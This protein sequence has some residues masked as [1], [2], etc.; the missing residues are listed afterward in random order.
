MVDHTKD[1]QRNVRTLTIPSNDSFLMGNQ[2]RLL[3]VLGIWLVTVA[4]A[5]ERVVAQPGEAGG[6]IEFNRD[7]RPIF[8]QYC[9]ACHGGVKAAA[10]LNVTQRDSVMARLEA[11]DAASSE[12]FRRLF[13]EDDSR[14]P[15][16]DHDSQPND[17]QRAIIGRWINQGA[18]WQ[19]H[20]S[21]VPPSRHPDPPASEVVSGVSSVVDGFLTRGAK[22][23]DLP[24]AAPVEP[25]R[26]LRRVTLAL[27]GVTASVEDS[28]RFEAD[29]ARRGML[30]Y[31]AEVDR[32]LAS[33]A[34]GEHW[35][36]VWLDQMRYADSRGLG[37][38]GRRTIWKY[39]DWVID[40]INQDMPFDQFTIRQIAGDLLP[41]AT[42]DDQIATAAQRLTQMSEEGGTDDEEFRIAAVIDRIATNW[43]VWQGLSLACAQCHDHPYDPISQRDFYRSFAIFN[44]TADCDVDEEFPIVRAPVHASDEDAFRVWAKQVDELNE[45]LWRAQRDLVAKTSW[46]TPSTISAAA[47]KGT[48][49]EVGRDDRANEF[50]VVGEPNRDSDFVIRIPLTAPTHLAAIQI[51]LRPM[52][53]DVARRDS[54]W[55]G[56]LS[57]V[58]VHL[59][60][61]GIGL[62]R[63]TVPLSH[64]IADEPMPLLDPQESLDSTSEDGFGAYSRIDRQRWAVFVCQQ[65]QVIDRPSTLIVTMKHRRWILDSFPLVPKRVAIAWCD[66]P[67]F[68]PSFESKPLED[69]R[70]ARE[71]I[72]AKQ[73]SVPTTTVPVL[74]ALRPE[75]RRPTFVFERGLFLTKGEAVDEGLPIA[76]ADPENN[77]CDDRLA[78]ARWLVSDRN[79]LTARVTVNRI[80]ARLFGIGLVATEEDLGAA[81]DLPL[82]AALL[83]HL[84]VT[85]REDHHWS[86]KRLVRSLV[87]T[88]AFGRDAASNPKQKA[89]DPAN[90][91]LSVGPR[92]RLSAEVIRDSALHASGLW[93]HAIGGPPVHP[94]LPEGVW[95]P[96]QARDLWPTPSRGEVARYRRSIYIYLKRS[97]PYPT[98]VTFDAPS[99]ESCTARRITTNSPLQSLHML[100]D[101]V[102]NECA[103]ALG[104]R[105]MA[106]GHRFET[107]L[108]WAFRAI[109]GRSPTDAQ[110]DRLRTYYEARVAVGGPSQACTDTAMVLLNLDESF[111]P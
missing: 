71:E 26:W 103:E 106:A 90:R 17:E 24:L 53:A 32:L 41:S 18:A 36:S 49:V 29:V 6:P 39:R 70:R 9:A 23:L 34:F 56:V 102:F 59:E 87:M 2:R 97:I 57:H 76:L 80:W 66:D 47:T 33:P 44:N 21:L 54:E 67:T 15:P 13:A 46:V 107:R 58:M 40:A 78:F 108:E 63:T 5:V 62:E 100:N 16:A 77:P 85:F 11:G 14:M 7:I 12:L 27:H 93:D 84:A 52:D 91:W 69:L 88:D 109:L 72:L 75:F 43:Q 104:A 42:L 8:N 95:Q 94:P 98:M 110:H 25:A 35:A 79:T 82:D 68:H 3:R 74:R 83:D 20:W 92:P 61:Q 96:F 111:H 28:Y 1:P 50:H 31:R 38:D 64:V 10:D 48:V 22:S 65:P 101:E 89:I 51:L 30:A 99:R 86:I 19:D 37:Q 81:G 45:E 73:A 60:Q 4:A 55:G 105:M